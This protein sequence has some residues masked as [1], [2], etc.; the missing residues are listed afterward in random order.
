MGQVTQEGMSRAPS[1]SARHFPAF[2][3][4]ELAECLECFL[5][6]SPS[7]VGFKLRELVHDRVPQRLDL[8]QKRLDLQLRRDG[9]LR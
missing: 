9:F 7:C 2:Q 4:L 6:I 3:K 8:L 5:K 1:A